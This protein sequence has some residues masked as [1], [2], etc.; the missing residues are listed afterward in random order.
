MI[1][2]CLSIAVFEREEIVEWSPDQRPEKTGA[3]FQTEFID[4]SEA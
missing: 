2:F 1:D 3:T 4:S